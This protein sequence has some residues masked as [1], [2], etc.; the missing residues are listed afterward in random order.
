MIMTEL[1][2]IVF[3][4]IIYLTIRKTIAGRCYL[5]SENTLAECAGSNQP[6]SSMYTNVL[7][8]YTEPCN[9]Q[10]VLFRNENGSIIR[11]CS[12][13]YGHMTSK[14][15]GWHDISPSIKA[16]FCDSHLCN[17]GTYE[18]PEI[19]IK[20][21]GIINNQINLSPQELFILA[22]NNPSLIQT[23]QQLPR[24]LYQCYSCT[25]RFQGCGEYLDPRYASNY[26]RPCPSS[27][28]I[29]RNP[30]DLN[31][32]TRDCSIFWPQ[33]HA[34]SGL[35]KL[36]GSDAFFCQE[37]L[38]NGISFD[39]I[40][41]IFHNQLPAVIT[42]PTFPTD[43]NI[44]IPTITTTSTTTTIRTTIDIYNDSII[45]DDPDL[46]DN[47]IESTTFIIS[48]NSTN[49]SI[50]NADMDFT[51]EIFIN[52]T[53]INNLT[54]S[55]SNS[56]L[57]GWNS[58]DTSISLFPINSTSILTTMQIDND[59]DWTIFNTSSILP[60]TRFEHLSI[61]DD[62]DDFFSFDIES[63][64]EINQDTND[65]FFPSTLIPS[66]ITDNHTQLLFPYYIQNNKIKDQFLEY[67]KP[68]PTLAMPPFSW[69]LNMANKNKNET[70]N[71]TITKKQNVHL[72]T[73]SSSTTTTTTTTIYQTP[74]AFFEY[75]KNKQCLHDGRLNSD[76]L[77]I[78]L[79]AF[80]GDNCE[81]VLCEQEPA[82]I[83]SFILEHECQTDH[84]RYLCPK[85]CQINDCSSKEI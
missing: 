26:I 53:I 23:E 37:S 12:W 32:L 77:C 10:C 28:I 17:N 30:N 42:F 80:T 83:C 61:D 54:F 40:M 16:Y 39:L 33:V 6:D 73:S 59:D 9:G 49:S 13:T 18:Q 8:Y 50:L 22:G 4:F 46:D 69:M 85:F 31:L 21:I 5:C 3:V 79:P 43:E 82:H 68:I 66:S 84:I 74:S 34:K 25:A 57:Y 64:P 27:C 29:F 38:C 62:T 63:N 1:H 35:H 48:N 55:E 65:Y 71:S 41:G 70:I 11:G 36:L 51:N 20:R 58:N 67:I 7:Q 19:S 60:V 44:S 75:C 14:S 52:S 76:C 45:W 56:S 81:T 2:L 72:T 15:I 24:R 78:C 47:L